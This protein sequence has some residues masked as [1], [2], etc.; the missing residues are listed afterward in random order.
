MRKLHGTVSSCNINNL[1]EQ[2]TKKF[3]DCGWKVRL[4]QIFKPTM[5][6]GAEN[7]VKY[8]IESIKWT[9]GPNSHQVYYWL[10]N[11]YAYFFERK[12]FNSFMYHHEYSNI[13]KC[14][15]CTFTP[16]KINAEMFMPID[17]NM[18]H[19]YN[20]IN[21]KVSLEYWV[22]DAIDSKLG[23][24]NIKAETK[25][26]VFIKF[27]QAVEELYYASIHNEKRKQ[28]A[29]YIQTA[30]MFVIEDEEDDSK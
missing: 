2:L 4:K 23:L 8:V 11:N 26:E 1:D 22:I 5:K 16:R 9:D 20:K 18:S 27:Q 25:H 17:I 13:E 24:Q 10:M 7:Q 15:M 19:V 12:E 14:I 28:L 3:G 30:D 29:K 21:D 6:S